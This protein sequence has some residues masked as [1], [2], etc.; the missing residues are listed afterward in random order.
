[1]N[2][3]NNWISL[4]PLYH[5]TNRNSK[6][7]CFVCNPMVIMQGR[8]MSCHLSSQ[9]HPT[10]TVRLAMPCIVLC[11]HSLHEQMTHTYSSWFISVCISVWEFSWI[12]KMWNIFRKIQNVWVS[13][14]L[15][16][17]KFSAED[18]EIWGYR[19]LMQKCE[20]TEI[21]LKVKSHSKSYFWEPFIIFFVSFIFTW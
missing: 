10:Y 1:M 19:N 18:T 2:K 14:T 6:A 15:K 17:R 5:V 13:F 21:E 16:M 4:E 8:C 9:F 11:K 7:N 3:S 20:D 12:Y